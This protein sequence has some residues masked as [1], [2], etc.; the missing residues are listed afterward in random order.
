M[1]TFGAFSEQAIKWIFNETANAINTATEEPVGIN[2]G[3]IIDIPKEDYE[4]VEE[5]EE[6]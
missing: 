5:S 6:N 1:S 2:K 3:R 4:V